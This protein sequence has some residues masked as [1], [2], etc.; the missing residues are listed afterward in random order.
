[1]LFSLGLI[2][3]QI[4]QH[5]FRRRA[6]LVLAEIQSL[7]LPKTP[8]HEAQIEFQR[9]RA[10]SEFGSQCNAQKCSL[11]VTLDQIVLGYLTQRNV[12][13]RLDDYFR[14]RLNL[15]YDTGPF[16][17]L[18]WVL[19]RVY[20]RIGGHPARVV[21]TVG[22][23][24]GIVWSKGFSVFI[25]TYAQEVSGFFGSTPGSYTLIGETHSV[26]RFDYFGT[27]WID[28]QLRLH[29]DYLIGRPGGCT[30][31]VLGWAKFTPY[32]EPAEV[33]RLM[34]LDLSCLTRWHPCLN[35]MDIMPAAWAHYLEDQSRLDALRDH[36]ACSP[37]IIELLGRDSTNMAT[38][39]ILGYRE[40]VDNGGHQHV[41]TRIRVLERLKGVPD[42]KVGETRELSDL[43]GIGGDSAR[44]RA[45]TQLIFFSGWSPLSEMR[46][47]PGYAC[48]ILSLNETNLNLV[49]RGIGQDYTTNDKAE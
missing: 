43:S 10:N 25:E 27:N 38:G 13:I 9:W 47:D 12:F 26:P 30:T 36:L 2:V 18:E 14:W 4:E 22:M 6:E 5:L 1:V 34:Q 42:W 3:S 7:E 44:L 28:A 8:W 46:I 29:P 24:D 32:T 48:P 40:R 41:G 33:H 11:T 20:L 45:G 23:R 31:C 49:R 39:E 37:S 17:R 21:A 15:A 16:V 35:Q 19:F